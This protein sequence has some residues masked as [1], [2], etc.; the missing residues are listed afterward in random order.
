[1]SYTQAI[2]QSAFERRSQIKPIESVVRA[3]DSSF[4]GFGFGN[5]IGFALVDF[6]FAT[7]VTFLT[8]LCAN[9]N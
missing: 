7:S 6:F 4:D 9:Q 1:M 8:F 2:P 5:P 3:C